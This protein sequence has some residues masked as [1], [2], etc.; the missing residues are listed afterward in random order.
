MRILIT[1]NGLENRAGT[2]LYVRDLAIALQRRGHE[3]VCFAPVLGDVAKEISDRGIEVV[4]TLSGLAPPDIIHGQHHNSAVLAYL[5]FPNV[6]AVQLC[7]GVLPWQEAPLARFANIRRYVAV[8]EACRAYLMQD[9]K[10]PEWAIT[11]ILN[12]V[13]LDR[14]T[15]TSLAKDSPARQKKA[16]LY[17]NIA[18]P[19]SLE[20]FQR[21]C[22]RA[23][24]T[25]DVAGSGSGKV[26]DAPE[27]VLCEYGIV[28]AKARASLE[29]MASGCAVFL[30]DYGKLGGLVTDDRF[31]AL[32][33]FNFGL[34]TLTE[35]V[36]STQ[37]EASLRQIDWDD[38]AS[39]SQHVRD[40]AGFEQVTSQWESLY[41]ELAD[42][43]SVHDVTPVE[44]SANYLRAILPQLA[45]RDTLA[46]QHYHAVSAGIARDQD[47]SAS[48][49][50]ALETGDS[51][52][53]TAQ[54]ALRLDPSN[55]AARDWV[56]RTKP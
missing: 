11:C 26:L 45:E 52:R 7:H 53:A 55:K 46:A 10:I 25:L 20:P 30:A 39:V 14:F 56:E 27:T 29:A 19:A 4:D 33:P 31:D 47:M 8:D 50:A 13:D 24:F 21:A 41:A 51:R 1:N 6:P 5:A 44:A 37:I 12:G 3:I 42:Q 54:T 22:R 38:A 2:E 49:T 15:S 36:E 28:F 17:S 23:G 48:L 34:R 9:H 43:P 18:N 40:E 35:P 32:R 16:L